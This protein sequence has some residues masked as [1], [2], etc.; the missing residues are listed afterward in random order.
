MKKREPF[1]GSLFLLLCQEKTEEGE[2]M[3]AGLHRRTALS[4][5]DLTKA[6]SGGQTKFGK[7][8]HILIV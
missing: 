7:M 4:P 5:E 1:F 3:S 6:E 8:G 2:E